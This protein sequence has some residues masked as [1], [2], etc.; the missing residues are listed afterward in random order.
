MGTHVFTVEGNAGIVV[1]IR[2]F[3]ENPLAGGG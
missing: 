1:D 3:Q 2:N